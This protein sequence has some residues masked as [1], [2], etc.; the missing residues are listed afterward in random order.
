MIAGPSSSLPGPSDTPNFNATYFG[1]NL[2]YAPSTPHK[3]IQRGKE[4]CAKLCSPV[5]THQHLLRRAKE[6][7]FRIP[8]AYNQLNPNL[9]PHITSRIQN[10]TRILVKCAIRDVWFVVGLWSHLWSRVA[11]YMERSSPRDEPKCLRRLKRKA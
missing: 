1:E 10:R 9:E 5:W 2:C 8:L 3:G 7:P 11:W 6:G 4:N